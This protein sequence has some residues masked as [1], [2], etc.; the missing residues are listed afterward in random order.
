MADKSKIEWTD[1]SWN[2]TRGC[3]K[4]SPGCANCYAHRF[5]E[6]FRGVAGHPYEQ[7]FDLRLVPEKLSDPQRYPDGTKV[8]VNSM[9]DLFF[10]E[11]PDEFIDRVFAVMALCP[12]V[13][14]QVLTKRAERMRLYLT[15]KHRHNVIEL[16]AERLQPASGS[17]APKHVLPWPLP[18][19]WAGVSCE[20]Q[21][22]FDKRVVHLL[23]T[24]AA[25]RFVSFEPLIG[26]IEI[27]EQLLVGKY[28]NGCWLGECKDGPHPTINWVIVGSE[29]GPGRR[30]TDIDWVR[31]IRDQCV[32]AGVPFFL[33]QLHVD[34][35][36]VS[37]PEL[38]GFVWDQLPEVTT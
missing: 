19:L 3:K 22:N 8:F 37:M 14:F 12:T 6:R 21:P 35:K 26:T 1:V 29:S 20:D 10:E 24:P 31:Q 23:Q 18:N 11:I 9:S 7:G 34:G 16:S 27:P 2:P 38:D 5:A 28:C 4:I 17:F 15:D 36:K 32:E 30:E 13:T 33:K 25:V